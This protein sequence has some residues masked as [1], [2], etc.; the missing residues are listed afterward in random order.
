MKKLYLSWKYIKKSLSFIF[1]CLTTHF[2]YSQ[3]KWYPLAQGVKGDYGI[4]TEAAYDGELYVGGWFY[5]AGNVTA[6]N[7]ARWSGWNWDSVGSGLTGGMNNVDVMCVYN[8][9]LYV[10]GAFFATDGMA[11]NNIA[12]WDGNQWDTLSS[13]LVYCGA[14]LGWADAMTVYNGKLYVAGA[15]CHAGGIKA[16]NI[17]SWDG[18]KWDSVSSGINDSVYALA[19]YNGKLY[20][21]GQFTR[22]GNQTVSNIACW[23]GIQWT[24]LGAGTN[25]PVLALMQY[26]GYLY[27]GGQFTYA[28]GSPQIYIARWNGSAWSAVGTGITTSSGSGEVEAF[29]LFNGLLYAGGLFNKSGNLV[30]NNIAS[31]NGTNWDTVS[32]QGINNTVDAIA[33]FDSAL[34]AAGVFT[35]A[36]EVAALNIAAWGGASLGVT[37]VAGNDNISTVY[38]NPNKGAFTL[39]VTGVSFSGAAIMEVYNMLGEKVYNAKIEQI[40]GD[41]NINMG[42]QTSGIYLYRLLDNSG[43]FIGCG[44]IVINN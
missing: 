2:G 30:V 37:P 43:G 10:G 4:L 31:W 24:A 42:T 33:V 20:A 19:V 18:T 6:N 12:S 1:I 44:K 38:P 13:G 32:T 3:S 35:R 23:D 39:K 22:A 15:F 25:L 16:N 29:G 9:K 26:N 34:F 5:Q 14:G 28:G 8:G 36:G 41:N 17:A 27:A 40:A 7:V 21:G 11:A